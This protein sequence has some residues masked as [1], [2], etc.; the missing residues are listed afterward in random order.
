MKKIYISGPMKGIPKKNFPLF[1]RTES[2]IRKLG[3]Y[4]LNP[5]IFPAGLSYAEYLDLSMA[6]LKCADV[7]FL[8]PHWTDSLGARTEHAYAMATCI[9]VCIAM[10]QLESL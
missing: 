8:L 6:L 1:M 2:I 10:E 7:I 9:D 3:H 5:A 4:P